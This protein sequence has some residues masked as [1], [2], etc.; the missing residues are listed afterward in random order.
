MIEILTQ[1]DHDTG[2][3]LRAQARGLGKFGIVRH[4]RVDGNDDTSVVHLRVTHIT[5]FDEGNSLPINA[6]RHEELDDVLP[7]DR[8]V[9]VENDEYA[10]TTILVDLEIIRHRLL[11]RPLHLNEP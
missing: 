8:R 1:D 10:A 6:R 5:G 7:A 9:R 11:L 3:G 2:R 4:V